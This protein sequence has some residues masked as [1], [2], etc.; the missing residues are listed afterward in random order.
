MLEP[1]A[2]AFTSSNTLTGRTGRLHIFQTLV[3]SYRAQVFS[4]SR[5]RDYLAMQPACVALLT[6]LPSGTRT[7]FTY[8]PA[9]TASP[10]PG[11]A[12]SSLSET[13]SE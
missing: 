4:Q 8:P 3:P 11:R 7:S 6:A 12:H 5:V 13:V 1:R 2:C 10:A 9:A